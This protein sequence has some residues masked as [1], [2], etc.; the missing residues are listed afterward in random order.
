MSNG[1]PPD[2]QQ[3][4]QQLVDTLNQVRKEEFQQGMKTTAALLGAFGELS[5]GENLN[6]GKAMSKFVEY[7]AD[8]AVLKDLQDQ[9]Q[10]LTSLYNAVVSTLSLVGNPVAQIPEFKCIMEPSGTTCVTSG[11]QTIIWQQDQVITTSAPKPTP[12]VGLPSAWVYYMHP[13]GY[14]PVPPGANPSDPSVTPIDVGALPVAPPSPPG[15][16]AGSSSGGSGGTTG[17]GTGGTTGGGLGPPPTP[18]PTP[19]PTPPPDET[20]G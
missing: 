6:P 9:D 10:I 5:F 1:N 18:T 3:A 13:Q 8:K 12:S 19:T 17:G 14:G 16:G 11:G 20:G 15:S 7:L 2:P 4:L